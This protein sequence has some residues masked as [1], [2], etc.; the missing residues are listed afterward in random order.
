VW[1]FRGRLSGIEAE[2]LALL[3]LARR[4]AELWPASASTV[5]GRQRLAG[6]CAGRGCRRQASGACWKTTETA[7]PRWAHRRRTEFQGACDLAATLLHCSKGRHRLGGGL[8]RGHH[9]GGGGA[10]GGARSKTPSCW[11]ACTDLR[12]ELRA[13]QS[14]AAPCASA[15]KGAGWRIGPALRSPGL[16]QTA[17]RGACTAPS[18]CRVCCALAPLAARHSHLRAPTARPGAGGEKAGRRSQLAVWCMTPR[19]SAARVFIRTQR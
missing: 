11:P 3:E 4:L 5:A 10:A 15:W 1:R 12:Q 19:L 14:G 17:G 9:P 18:A 8:W 16:R 6:P 13:S 2:T 7:R